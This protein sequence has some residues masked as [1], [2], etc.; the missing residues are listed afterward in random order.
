MLK[1]LFFFLLA[2]VFVP[3]VFAQYTYSDDCKKAYGLILELRFAAAQKQIDYAKKKDPQNL[4]P[5]LL[6]NYIDFL[7]ITLDEN[8]ELFQKISEKKKMRLQQWETGPKNSPYYRLGIA[9]L[10][11]QWAFS[12]VL[13]G[14]YLTAAYEIN[15]AYH[16]LEENKNEFP[17]FLPNAL[18]LG[19]LHSMIGVVPEQYRWAINILGLYGTI[20][21]GLGELE[22]LLNSKNAE[23][24]H[25]KPEALFLYT[26]LKLN[27][28]TDER[29]IDQLLAVYQKPDFETMS[30]RSPLIHFSKAVVMMRKDNDKAIVFLESKPKANDAMRFYYPDFM[31]AQAKLYKFDSNSETLFD[32]YVRKFPGDNFKRT[33]K[34]KMAWSAFVR[35]DT[36][37]YQKN[38]NA[39]LNLKSTKIDA[40]DAALKE[41]KE[42]QKGFLPNL[43]LLKSRIYFDGGYLAEALNVLQKINTKSFSDQEKVEL[44]YRRGRIYHRMDSLNQALAFYQHALALGANQNSY[45]AGNSC[46]MIAEIY[47]R[48][49][50]KRTSKIYYEKCLELNFD[51]YS[52]SIRA[53]A[54]A[55]LQRVGTD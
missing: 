55:G 24:Q 16:L 48:K 26:F 51:E 18:G 44:A 12:R 50:E 5:I 2:V 43:F 27:L 32:T 20:D 49:N 15:L 10:N 17:E 14:E 41:A 25:F 46:L 23:F 9:Q 38:M 35:G 34:Q 39:I 45:Y 1:R 40:D 31:L 33:A 3:P 52:R 8:Q 7:S 19:V 11:M 42:A 22:A 4:I 53:K 21:Q 30:M 29:R 47:E 28:K 37:A 13:F 6:E 36:L 54:Q